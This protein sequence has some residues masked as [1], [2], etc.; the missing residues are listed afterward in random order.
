MHIAMSEPI[1][2]LNQAPGEPHNEAHN[3]F[4]LILPC[5]NPPGAWT[6]QLIEDFHLLQHLLPDTFIQLI[7]VNDGSVRNFTTTQIQELKDAIPDIRIINHPV[8]RGKGYAL[9]LGVA[10]AENPYQ[11]CSDYDMPF[12]VE[13]ICRAYHQLLRGSDVVAGVRGRQYTNLLPIQR[14]FI[15]R[16]NRLLNR[17]VL[18]LPVSDAQAGL[19]AFNGNGRREFLSTR[20]NGFLYDSEFVRRSGKNRQLAIDKISIRCRKDIRF[21]DFKLKTL[22]KECFNFVTI[23]L[24]D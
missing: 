15:T 6:Y 20:I 7:L 12:G 3:R 8:N 4:D 21:S 16:I 10:M 13:A 23:L 17:Y 18:R 19:K 1:T 5:C 2:V 11:V 9:R 24:I 14:R 22:F